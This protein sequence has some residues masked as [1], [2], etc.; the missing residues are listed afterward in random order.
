[1]EINNL[2]ILLK[3]FSS[4]GTE[5]NS[6]KIILACVLKLTF[7]FLY[8]SFIINGLFF[9]SVNNLVDLPPILILFLDIINFKSSSE[10]S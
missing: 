4:V 1:M 10:F 5:N 2:K 7:T 6:L 9:I 3:N 8:I